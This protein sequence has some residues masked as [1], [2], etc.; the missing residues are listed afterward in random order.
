MR[1]SVCGG[2]GTVVAALS[3]FDGAIAPNGAVVK[4]ENEHD[5]D[6]IVGVEEEVE[7]VGGTVVGA[8]AE[9]GA[10]AA[11]AA[12][13]AAAALAAAATAAATTAIDDGACCD[14]PV[15]IVRE[16]WEVPGAM[17]PS[18]EGNEYQ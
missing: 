5:E 17:A 10:D 12:A 15:G 1:D 3:L 18:C 8:V 6:K 14:A 11:A 16:F 9:A 2:G 13:A 7:E 4:G